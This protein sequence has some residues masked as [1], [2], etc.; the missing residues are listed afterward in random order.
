METIENV[1]KYIQLYTECSDFTLKRIGVLLSKMQ[2][3]KIVHKIKHDTKIVYVQKKLNV[4]H[5][6]I[7]LWSQNYFMCNNISFEDVA[8]KSRVRNTIQIRNA[9]C[10]EAYKNGF[11]YTTIAKYIG[12]DHSTIIHCV[13]KIKSR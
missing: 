2:I 11:G 9:Y 12:Y 13:N 5:K 7:E 3:E 10:I 1:L 4:Q 8:K 6:T